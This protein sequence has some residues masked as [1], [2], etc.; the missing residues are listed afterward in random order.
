[1]KILCYV[2]QAEAF[3]KGIDAP[4]SSVQIEVDPSVLT[5][6]QRDFIA[7]RLNDGRVFGTKQSWRIV[8]PTFEGFLA[9]LTKWMGEGDQKPKV[10]ATRTPE[11]PTTLTSERER[12][13]RER[14]DLALKRNQ[15]L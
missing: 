8:E 10:E 13:Y 4:H 14:A 15:V 12:H 5:Q 1:M 11:E 2:N 7:D 3:R 6:A 9:M